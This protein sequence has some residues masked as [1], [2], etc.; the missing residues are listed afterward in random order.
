MSLNRS[1]YINQPAFLKDELRT[2]FKENPAITIFDIGAC[3]GEDSIRYSRLFPNSIIYCFEPIPKNVEL[4]KR[5]IEKYNVRNI[6]WYNVALSSTEGKAEFY[7]S[8]G[9]PENVP[10]TDW[11]YGNKSSSLLPPEKHKEL[12][13]FI[14]FDHKIVVETTTLKS[15]CESKKIDKIDFIHMDVQGAELFVL[16]GAKDYINS[17]KSIWL[18]VS[19][20]ALYKNQALAE[21][22]NDF[23]SRNN[24]VLVKDCLTEIQGDRL[25]ISKNFFLNYIEISRHFNKKKTFLKKVIDKL[26]FK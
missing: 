14:E 12:A 6:F 22:I 18:E 3:E 17:I 24:F 5:N 11:D 4:L 19:K 10:D 21:D 20:V 7:V 1:D 25:Y 9:R 8:K 2:L 23:M 26:S 16:D 13:P 15:F